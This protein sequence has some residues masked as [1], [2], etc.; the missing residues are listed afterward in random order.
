MWFDPLR[1][2][3]LIS[4]LLVCAAITCFLVVGFDEGFKPCP[5]YKRTGTTC[6]RSS[7]TKKQVCKTSVLT[8]DTFCGQTMHPR[9]TTCC[10]VPCFQNFTT[11]FDSDGNSADCYSQPWQDMLISTWAWT[12]LAIGLFGWISLFICCRPCS[13]MAHLVTFN[14]LVRGM[15]PVFPPRV[16]SEQSKKGL[17]EMSLSLDLQS[18]RGEVAGEAVPAN[19]NLSPDPTP[20]V[21]N[22]EQVQ[23]V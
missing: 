23:V 18:V 17:M 20:N 3:L 11:Y 12:C 8:F 15:E 21:S 19:P 6:S 7:G 4:I 13:G 1:C 14:V 10:R 9:V 16:L 5:S 22:V 2:M